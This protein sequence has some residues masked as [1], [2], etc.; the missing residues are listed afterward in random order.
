[1]SNSHTEFGWISS[2]GLEEDSVTDGRTERGECHVSIAFNKLEDM[3]ILKRSPDLLNNVK[4]GQD[5]L[6]IIIKHILFYWGFGHFGQV[7]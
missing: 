6:R 3:T 4:I 7:T 1:M 2:I 5:Q